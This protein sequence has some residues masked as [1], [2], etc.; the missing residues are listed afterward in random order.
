MGTSNG[1]VPDGDALA[2][3]FAQSHQELEKCD[4]CSGKI[5]VGM[6]IAIYG[7]DTTLGN[8]SGSRTSRNN[9]WL[10]RKYCSEC[11]QQ[12]VAFPHKGTNEVLYEATVTDNAQLTNC[13]IRAHSPPDEGVPWDASELFEAAY[14]RS[15]EAQAKELAEQGYS[16]GHQDIVDN[17]KLS[18]ITVPDLYDAEGDL[19]LSAQ[20][21]DRLREQMMGRVS[22]PFRLHPQWL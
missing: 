22:K 16:Y 20:D 9:W 1:D 17:L 21:Q 10:H 3:L 13:A 18:D 5:A 19:Q 11:D 7:S 14:G 8:G 2:Q 4:Y 6:E 15:L 12:E